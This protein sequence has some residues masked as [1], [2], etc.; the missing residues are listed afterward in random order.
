MSPTKKSDTA[1]PLSRRPA[2]GLADLLRW[3]VR[4]ECTP[5]SADRGAMLLGF[6]R[7]ADEDTP[8]IWVER[9]V[10][11]RYRV[12]TILDPA[13]PVPAPPTLHWY[14]VVERRGAPPAA[15]GEPEHG[16]VC[17]RGV[18]PLTGAQLQPAASRPLLP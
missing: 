15:P 4:P 5:E 12:G 3:V 7:R 14:A 6:A 1:L 11:I 8:T 18:A 13:P 2:A 17:L 10:D 9:S 16:P